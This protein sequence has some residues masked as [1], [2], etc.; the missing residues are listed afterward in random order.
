MIYKGYKATIEYDD[1]IG[2]FHG[3]VWMDGSMAT[4][5]ATDIEGL[6]REFAISMEDYFE[7]CAD[8][9]HNPKPPEASHAPLPASLA[10]EGWENLLHFHDHTAR[11]RY[12]EARETF[13]GQAELDGQPILF[14]G[15]S[16][17]GLKSAFAQAT[18]RH[19]APIQQ[20]A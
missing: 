7:A 17:A 5:E 3:R 16:V 1:S 20:A 14:E 10:E 12:D 18:A 19:Q 11:I 4:F 13:I 9:G 8:W 6:K 2:F 15:T